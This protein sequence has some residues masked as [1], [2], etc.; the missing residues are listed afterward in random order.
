[1]QEKIVSSLSSQLGLGSKEPMVSAIIA[2]ALNGPQ[3]DVLLSSLLG[4]AN[5]DLRVLA[6][7][8]E[9]SVGRSRFD[10]VVIYE[11]QGEVVPLVIEVKVSAL[12]ST[13]QMQRYQKVAKTP[14]FQGDIARLLRKSYPRLA[15]RSSR[16]ARFVLLTVRHPSVAP[17]GLERADIL[18]TDFGQWRSNLGDDCRQLRQA[19][20]SAIAKAKHSWSGCLATLLLLDVLDYLGDEVAAQRELIENISQTTLEGISEVWDEGMLASKLLQQAVL[21]EIREEFDWLNK[22]AETP[23]SRWWEHVGGGGHLELGYYQANWVRNYVSAVDGRTQTV[24]AVLRL[25]PNLGK[26][27]AEEPSVSVT[28]RISVEP[29]QAKDSLI[30]S[31]EEDAVKEFFTLR[32]DFAGK[33]AAN[34]DPEHGYKRQGY[35][36]QTGELAVTLKPEQTLREAARELWGA[37]E[38]LATATSK[39][40]S[41]LTVGNEELGAA[42]DTSGDRPAFQKA[43]PSEGG[44]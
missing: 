35:Y 1:M 7:E 21:D 4:P 12:A 28:T 31:H 44:G 23:F 32:D 16:E 22:T 27:T 41:S 13:D 26:L 18:R 42:E 19:A 14:A 37:S 29:Y 10:V 33:V 2:A 8:A 3:A 9:V 25:R 38:V 40:L 20:A 36:L 30:A 43:G 5:N 39:A 17:E 6:A 24:R 15:G 11:G 34:I